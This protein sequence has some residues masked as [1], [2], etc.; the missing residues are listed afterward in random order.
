M[1]QNSLLA[2]AALALLASCEKKSD[3]PA[4]ATDV[5]AAGSPETAD[6]A[7]EPIEGDASSAW[8]EMTGV[9]AQTGRCGDYTQ[10]WRLEPEAFHHH[11]MHCAIARLELLANGARALAQCSV[12]GDDDGVEDA[13]QFLRQGD[14]SLTIVQEANGAETTGLFMCEGE[15]TEL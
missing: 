3:A 9:W 8:I 11:E 15:G 6:P 10:E 1:K 5:A 13:Y 12:E 14:A 2:L 7:A 4:A